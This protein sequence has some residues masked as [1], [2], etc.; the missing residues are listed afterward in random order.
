MNE[1]V[2]SDKGIQLTTFYSSAPNHPGGS[3]QLAVGSRQYPTRP[4]K[5]PFMFYLAAADALTVRTSGEIPVRR[6]ILCLIGG[7][8]SAV[9]NDCE[10]SPD[11]DS[12]LPRTFVASSGET[13]PYRIFIPEISG[14]RH[15][16][17]LVVFLHG[18]TGSG[19]DNISQISGSNWRGAHVWT[20]ADN[21]ARYP[22]FVLAPQLPK[23]WRWDAGGHQQLSLYAKA[24]VELLAELKNELPIDENRVYLTGQSLGGWGTW[25]L[26]AKRP[27]LFA[28]AVPVCGG[29][30]PSTAANFRDVSVW[31]FHGRRDSQIPVKRS[32]EMVAALREVG[33]TV[34][35][36]EYK[37]LGHAI[38]DRA[39]AE[40]DLIDWLFSQNRDQ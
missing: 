27:G 5:K 19:V 38:W 9:L 37:L 4:H 40:R 16:Y 35:Y 3:R 11:V 39:Y 30:D 8:F 31:A 13:L 28:A 36:T 18:G 22:C 7:L 14:S 26:I 25:D 24:L 29:G 34:R 15:L 12:M 21:Q 10:M 23:L 17:P 32:R 2:K 6:A 1:D 33:S 20:Q